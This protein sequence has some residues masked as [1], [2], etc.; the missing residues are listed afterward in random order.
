MAECSKCIHNAVCKT[1]ESCDGYVSGCEHFL[2]KE[3]TYTLEGLAAKIC[4]NYKECTEKE[5]P[6]FVYC[7]RKEKGTLT[8]LK[9]VTR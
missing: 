5:C 9:R 7:C 2:A 4:G 8:W 6:G 1:A 3:T